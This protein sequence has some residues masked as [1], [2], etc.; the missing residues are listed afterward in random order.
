MKDI[1]CL[2]S[3]YRTGFIHPFQQILALTMQR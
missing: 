1:P 3:S 2:R